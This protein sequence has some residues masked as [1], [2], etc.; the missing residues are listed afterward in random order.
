MAD[1]EV[2]VVVLLI[3]ADPLPQ[4]LVELEH[5]AKD[6]QV[7]TLNVTM[8]ALMAEAGVALVVQELLAM[9][10]E[11]LTALAL[12]AQEL[13]VQ[14]LEALLLT[15]LEAVEA[16]LELCLLALQVQLTEALGEAPLITT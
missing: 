12:E 13:P 3:L 15:L 11:L 7:V 9:V 14:F 1:L 4:P 5:Q 8:M 10:I 6:F 2:L 16:R